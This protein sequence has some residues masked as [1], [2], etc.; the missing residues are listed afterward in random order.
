MSSKKKSKG[1]AYKKKSTMK[2][3]LKPTATQLL[4]QVQEY[5]II[6]CLVLENWCESGLTHVIV[7]RQQPD[8]QFIFG[9]FLV[10]LLCLGVKDCFIKA[11]A[12][13]S[14]YDSHL[15]IVAKELDRL[16]ECPPDLAHAIIYGGVD[17]ARSLGF[18]PHSDYER[19]RLVLQ[20]RDSFDTLPDVE[21]GIKGKPRYINGPYDDVKFVLDTLTRNVGE[22]NF[23]HILRI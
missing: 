10:D 6:Q 3:L 15:R 21:F 9:N 8:G 12:T 2:S 13:Q 14:M 22:D 19:C 20:P 16:I 11:N 4:H 7:T 17:Y 5:P 23:D 1:K 18:E